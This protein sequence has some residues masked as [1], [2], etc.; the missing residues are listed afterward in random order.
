MC[1]LEQNAMDNLY[2]EIMVDWI[3][4][5]EGDVVHVLFFF[6][7]NVESATSYIRIVSTIIAFLSQVHVVLFPGRRTKNRNHG[8]PKIAGSKVSMY[9]S[10]YPSAPKQKTMKQA[11]FPHTLEIVR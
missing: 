1:T 10:R 3:D 7:K 5:S 2:N 8:C 11:S 6:L 9:V 4:W